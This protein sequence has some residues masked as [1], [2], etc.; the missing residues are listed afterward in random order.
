MVK[1]DAF[2]KYKDEHLKP[3]FINFLKS[4][5]AELINKEALDYYLKV[6]GEL[7]SFFEGPNKRY[8]VAA[9]LFFLLDNTVNNYELKLIDFAHVGKL[10]EGQ[11]K[12][13]NFL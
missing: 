1:Q 7:V 3:L 12:D 2:K 11:V 8:F 9:S 6:I 10:P 5:D 13:D 4:N